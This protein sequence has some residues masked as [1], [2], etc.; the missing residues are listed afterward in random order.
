MAKKVVFALEIEIKEPTPAS[1][2]NVKSIFAAIIKGY[3]SL[4]PNWSMSV[5]ELR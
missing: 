3:Q 1:I 2:D 4:H 5:L